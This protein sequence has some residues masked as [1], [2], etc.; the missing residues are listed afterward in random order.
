ML[1]ALDTTFAI[2]TYDYLYGKLLE[3]NQQ[4][5]LDTA[6]ID[7]FNKQQYNKITNYFLVP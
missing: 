7:S 3:H 6:K 2:L 4:L 1:Y 5:M